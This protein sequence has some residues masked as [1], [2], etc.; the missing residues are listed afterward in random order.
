MSI[1]GRGRIVVWEGASLWL[2]ASEHDSSEVQPHAHHALQI[3]FALKGD[4]ELCA[5]DECL[6]GPIV[7]VDSDTRHI[8]RAS[9][10]G[11][12]LFVAPESAAG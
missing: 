9:G 8:F 4:F 11:A 6:S 10:V 2:L 3:T 12:F 7:A 5:G 1:V